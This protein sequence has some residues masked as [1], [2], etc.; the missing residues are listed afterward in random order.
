M[1]REELTSLNKE[2]LLTYLFQGNLSSA[3]QIIENNTMR[4]RY[5]RCQKEFGELARKLGKSL[6]ATPSIVE[7]PLTIGTRIANVIE[8]G[9]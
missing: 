1:T 7:T 5:V 9:G 4:W 3:V 6:L 2:V 8:Q